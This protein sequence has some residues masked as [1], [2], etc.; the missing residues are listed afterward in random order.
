MPAT[1]A[2]QPRPLPREHAHIARQHGQGWEN[3]EWVSMH[4]YLSCDPVPVNRTAGWGAV[5]GGSSRTRSG[6]A[7]PRVSKRTRARRLDAPVDT[8]EPRT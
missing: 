8:L 7:A 5:P 3:A 4:R 1:T 2:P 6:W